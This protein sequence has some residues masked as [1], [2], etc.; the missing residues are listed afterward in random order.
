MGKQHKTHHDW[1]VR[2]SIIHGCSKVFRK[3]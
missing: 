2:I 3:L 1:R